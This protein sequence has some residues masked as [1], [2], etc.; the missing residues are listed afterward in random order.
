[1][2]SGIPPPSVVAKRRI[3]DPRAVLN[4]L[5]YVRSHVCAEH[6]PVARC[7][8]GPAAETNGTLGAGFGH[9]FDQISKCR[10][11]LYQSG[12]IPPMSGQSR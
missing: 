4:G 10:P 6:G 1:M 12:M 9:R 3:V 2:S 5:M 11:R 7:A 8:P